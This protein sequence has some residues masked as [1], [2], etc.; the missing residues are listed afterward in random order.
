MG[1]LLQFTIQRFPLWSFLA[2]LAA[3]WALGSYLT[4]GT[5][6]RVSAPAARSQAAAPPLPQE[7]PAPPQPAP[8]ERK[9]AA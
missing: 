5:A 8:A 1:G 9:L 2:M 6:Q 3:F 4:R 7:A